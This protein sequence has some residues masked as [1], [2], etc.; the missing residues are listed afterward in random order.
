MGLY[1]VRLSASR[2]RYFATAR[3][4]TIFHVGFFPE[5]LAEILRQQPLPAGWVSSIFDSK[6]TIV[7]RTHAAD[8]FVGHKGAPALLDRLAVASEGMVETKTLEGIKV[9]ALFTRS[10]V[11][12]WAVAIGV[13]TGELA[14]QVWRSVG[15]SIAGTF[16][17]VVFGIVAAGFAGERLARP[18][19]ALTAPALAHGRGEPVEIPPLGLREA[20]DL[21]GALME[22]SRLLVARTAERDAV[23]AQ[24]QEA[25]AEKRATEEAARARSAYFAYLSHELRTPLTAVLGYTELIASR[26]RATS[27]DRKFLDYCARIDAGTH[28]LMGVVDEILDYAKYEARELELHE[29]WLDAAAEVHAAVDLFAGKAEQA[30]V[31]LRCEIEPRLPPL[32]ADRVRLRQILL[33]LLSNA[34]KF[35]PDGGIVTVTATRRDGELVIR[36]EDTGIGIGADDLL[37]VISPSRRSS[38]RRHGSAK[39]RGS[40]S[41]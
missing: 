1:N 3:S 11:S 32:R 22:G 34:L 2:C 40:G 39:G 18:I 19:R 6:G 9:S 24:R 13:P 21:A 14:A 17:L 29:E 5:R 38:I 7:A 35:T 28:H 31:A 8:Q 20:D 36:V 10:Q 27:Q 25:L 26:T 37:R 16:V 12:N 4:S 33:N 23:E 30:H 15:L 41:P